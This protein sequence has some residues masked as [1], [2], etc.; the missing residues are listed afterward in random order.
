MSQTKGEVSKRKLL[1]AAEQLFAKKGFT[2]TKV[3]EIVASAGLTQA[4]FYLYFK[5]KDDIFQQLL[6]DFDQ[7]LIQL[8]SSRQKAT[9]L[10]PAEVKGYMFNTFKDLFI[11]LG[12]NP[13]LTRIALQHAPESD[14][15]RQKI[16][17]QI[18]NNISNN[19]HLGIVREGLDT[20]VTAES[21]VAATERL[22]NKYLLTGD[23]TEEELGKQVAEIFFNGIINHTGGV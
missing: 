4:A 18:S 1:Q 23:K 20:W 14:Q 11:L 17:E 13:N 6:H 3:S 9:E 21:I 2:S 22:V 8:S 15:I 16:V 10:L 19:Q 5:S 7:Q 12:K